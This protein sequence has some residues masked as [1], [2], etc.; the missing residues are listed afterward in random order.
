MIEYSN[1]SITEFE[2][3]SRVEDRVINLQ[4]RQDHLYEV[5]ANFEEFLRGAG[6]VFEGHLDIVQDEDPQLHLFPV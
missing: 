6:F 2:F 5:I 4:F 3:T 1:D